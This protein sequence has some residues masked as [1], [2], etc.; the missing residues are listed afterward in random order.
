MPAYLKSTMTTLCLILGS[1]SSAYGIGLGEAD[2][3]SRLGSPLDLSIPL[4]HL[5]D[6]SGQDLRI[7]LSALNDNVS[8]H[9]LDSMVGSKFQIDF[10]SETNSV[11]LR[12][13]E[14]VMEPYLAFTLS[15][16]W[17][18]GYL[19]REYTVLLDLPAIHKSNQHE[20][21]VSVPAGKKAETP[22]IV[23]QNSNTHSGSIAQ[24][25]KS[26]ERGSAKIFSG[27]KTLL[28]TQSSSEPKAAYAHD[29]FD[30]GQYRVARGDSLWRVASRLSNQREGDHGQW[31]ASVYQANH[32]AFIGGR[33]DLLKE[34][35]LLSIPMHC[36]DT[37]MVINADGKTFKLVDN[38]NLI[39][40]KGVQALQPAAA[41][42]GAATKTSNN[43]LPTS[44]SPSA[45]LVAKEAPVYQYDGKDFVSDPYAD[46]TT[47]VHANVALSP[48]EL[49]S[50]EEQA[51]LNKNSAAVSDVQS[52][53]SAR[54][55]NRRRVEVL[56]RQL[57]QA[58][59]LIEKQNK[60]HQLFS[61]QSSLVNSPLPATAELSNPAYLF[62]AMGWLALGMSMVMGYFMYR[63][64]SNSKIFPLSK[65]RKGRD[66]ASLVERS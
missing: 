43:S 66:F 65:K 39:A 8:G 64:R 57:D 60:Q 14:A 33:P 18:R 38:A 49:Y 26:L 2:L 1:F 46:Q 16:R 31:M 47:E 51:Q 7:A 5:G 23:A 42:K 52:A 35:Y 50:L 55:D 53:Q 13:D 3:R 63:D 56:E 36:S 19:K 6:L 62:R 59:A 29:D 9:P 11:R 20:I 10:D 28:S 54:D 41:T 48:L 44:P 27:N 25:S 4:H 34:A 30:D 15:V 58:L 32:Q 61:P 22:K 12:S 37:R 45:D 24:N 17:P 21:V 40:S